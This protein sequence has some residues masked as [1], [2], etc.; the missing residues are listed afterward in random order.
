MSTKLLS[1]IALDRHFGE[2]RAIL[3]KMIFHSQTFCMIENEYE[4][5]RPILWDLEK[6]YY[7]TSVLLDH[8]VPISSC[9]E[10]PSPQFNKSTAA[11]KS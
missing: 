9:K 3:K 7:F 6:V 8:I 4:K 1:I 11:S 2:L 5:Q 10:V